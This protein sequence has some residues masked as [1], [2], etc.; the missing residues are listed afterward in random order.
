MAERSSQRADASARVDELLVAGHVRDVRLS[1]TD[2]K[3][4]DNVRA[5]ADIG[6]MAEQQ[7]GEAL[8]ALKKRSGM[9]LSAIAKASGYSGRSSVQV[10][11]SATYDKVLDTEVAQKLADGLEGKG[12]PPIS[13]EEILALTG[14]LTP[15]AKVLQYEGASLV[16]LPRD[17]PIFGTSLGAP[18]DFDGTAIEQTMLNT[19]EIQGYLPRPTVLNH[20]RDAVYGLYVQGSSMA[21]RFE[22]GET[23]FV[24]ATK[25]ARPPRIGDDVVVYIRDVEE[26]DGERASAVL[27]KRL[28]RRTAEYTELEQFNP[29]V[30]FRI[31]ADRVLKM[32]RVIPWS[33]LLS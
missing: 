2:V 30:T 8:L 9:S 5:S 29:A 32:D 19:G 21:P 16:Q 7:T 13:R 14:V 22:D 26:D 6:R 31:P 4:V 1:R 11:F 12:T 23:I 28:V 10:F 27:V 20:L 18:R 25:Q 17:V 15:N 24:T 3:H 33:E